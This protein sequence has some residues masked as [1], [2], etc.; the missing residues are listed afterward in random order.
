MLNP[1]Y[2]SLIQEVLIAN[3]RKLSVSN[4]NYSLLSV[5]LNFYHFFNLYQSR[6]LKHFIESDT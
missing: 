1:I 6:I 3:G 2:H 4:G 5:L